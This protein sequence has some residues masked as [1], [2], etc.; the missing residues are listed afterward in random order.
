MKLTNS[1]LHLAVTAMFILLGCDA[2][3]LGQKNSTNGQAKRSSNLDVEA[4]KRAIARQGIEKAGIPMPEGQYQVDPTT[5]LANE[6]EARNQ[7]GDRGAFREM[8]SNG[9]TLLPVDGTQPSSGFG[10][11]EDAIAVTATARPVPSSTATPDTP[12]PTPN[13]SASATPGGPN[14]CPPAKKACAKACATAHAAA[15]AVAFAHASATACAWAEAWACVFSFQ[16][17]AK[18]CTWA[19]SSACSTAFASAFGFGF[20][21]DT[22]TVCNEQCSE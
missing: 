18:V 1:C 5:A 9:I 6:E 2:D 14:P 15:V 16:P 11:L 21:F 17:F 8:H 7:V 20:A 13:P 12:T 4:D 19:Q 22:E 10:L 3:Q